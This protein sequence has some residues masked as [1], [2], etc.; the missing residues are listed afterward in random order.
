MTH[1]R[2]QW[3][4]KP[5]RCFAMLLHYI[6]WTNLKKNK[7]HEMPHYIRWAGRLPR[8]SSTTTTFWIAY[9]VMSCRT[10]PCHVLH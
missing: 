4:H 3:Q 6:T 10:M 5:Q 7:T 1:D 9:R 8:S 2:K